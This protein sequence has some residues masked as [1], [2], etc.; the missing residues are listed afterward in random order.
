MTDHFA[1]LQEARRPWLDAGTLQVTFL[2]LSSTVHP[3]RSHNAPEHEKSLANQRFLEIN[4]A[5][6]CLREPKDRLAHLLELELGARPKDVQVILPGTMEVFMDISQLCRTVDAFLMERGKAGSPMVKV[7]MFE[8]AQEWSDRLLEQQRKVG[9]T[10]VELE[11]ELKAMN[12]VWESAPPSG[13][14]T[15]A[16]SLPLHR[17]EQ[18]YRVLSYVSR[19]QAQIQERLVRLAFD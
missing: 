14:P 10:R 5:Y 7:Q 19:W 12:S 15:R 16:G 2:Q 4:A 11:D 9:A 8:R 1:L 6:N 13:D 17:L 18:A 3:D